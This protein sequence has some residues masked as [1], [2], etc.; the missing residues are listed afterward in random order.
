MSI[1]CKLSELLTNK[2][3]QLFVEM[4]LTSFASYLGLKKAFGW[5]L[6]TLLL[7]IFQKQIIEYILYCLTALCVYAVV[8]KIAQLVTN[9]FPA[10]RAKIIDVEN[11][12]QCCLSIN[13]EIRDHLGKVALKTSIRDNFLENHN[14]ELNVGIAADCLAQHML[15]T[16]DG[17]KRK[18]IFVSVYQVVGFTELTG[19]R[20]ELK[21]IC[22]FPHGKDGIANRRIALSDPKFSDYEC[23]KCINS[24]YNSVTK[25]DCTTYHKSSPSRLKKIRHYIGMKLSCGDVLLGFVN[26]ELSNSTF[27]SSEDEMKTYLEQNI[28]AF[29]YL[30]EYQFL[31]K[32]FFSAIRPHLN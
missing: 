29:N 28:L 18:D 32:T 23:V 27:F 14:F 2:K 22:H 11:I 15:T 3:H 25:L 12:A 19:Q 10:T 13:N 24:P 30:I 8:A 4:T 5:S 1:Y 6:T 17:A 16:L 21:Y 9:A 26:I 31:K 20:S 7:P